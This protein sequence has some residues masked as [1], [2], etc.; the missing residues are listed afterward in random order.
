MV[1]ATT[2]MRC[3]EKHDPDNA[4]YMDKITR[5]CLSMVGIRQQP[6]NPTAWHQSQQ[7]HSMHP[8]RGTAL[9]SILR[10]LHRRLRN[11]TQTILINQRPSKP[12]IPPNRTP[13]NNHKY[14]IRPHLL[15]HLHQLSKPSLAAT[16]PNPAQPAD[17]SQ[18]SRPPPAS[19]D[20]APDLYPSPPPHPARTFKTPT[21]TH[22]HDTLPASHTPHAQSTASRRQ[23]HTAMLAGR[24]VWTSG[25][26]RSER[27]S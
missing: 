5:P 4:T 19:S 6:P 10:I 9:L 27:C 14:L 16:P 24:G 12:A 23:R 15:L 2:M 13:Q 8:Y 1:T 11:L 25:W 18:T 26:R 21:P 17:P 22:S 20:S 7:P 3:G